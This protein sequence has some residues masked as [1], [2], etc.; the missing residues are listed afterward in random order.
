MS[1]NTNLLCCALNEA[2]GPNWETDTSQDQIKPSIRLD[3]YTRIEFP[4]LE[5]DMI[6]VKNL[7]E[8]RFCETPFFKYVTDE[9]N[10]VISNQRSLIDELRTEIERLKQFETYYNMHR[11]MIHR[12]INN[13]T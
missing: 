3:I 2:L 8:Q 4:L 13:D 6:K 10:G 5:D 11:K 7:V 9:L 1:F 12:E